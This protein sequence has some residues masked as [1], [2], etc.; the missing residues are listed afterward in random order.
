MTLF[1]HRQQIQALGLRA[2]RT[3]STKEQR[4]P[5]MITQQQGAIIP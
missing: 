1:Q 5:T 4:I 2:W 3:P